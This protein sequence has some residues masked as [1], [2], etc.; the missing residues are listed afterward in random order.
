M[1]YS[2]VYDVRVRYSVDNKA[3]RSGTQGLKNDVRALGQEAK[4]TTGIFGRLGVAVVA[5][6]GARA[7]GKALI[8]FNSTVEDT[9]NQIA[10]MLALS[11]KTDL[12]Q[13][14]GVA[15]RLYSRLEKRAATLP[16]KTAEYVQM[17]GMLTQPLSNAGAT[18]KDMENLTVNA[19][20]GAKALGVSWDVAARDMDQA[21]R[22]QFHSVDQFTG[23]ILGSIGYTG[24]EGRKRFNEMGAD[25]RMEVLKAALMQ[26]QLTQL[27]SAQG[28]SFS[29]VLSTLQDTIEKTLGK[30]GQPIFKALG[31]EIR[32]WNKWLEANGDR[33]DDIAKTIG[34]HLV[35]G[36]RFVKDTLGFFVSHADTLIM[37][38]KVWAAVKIGSML[39]GGAGGLLG[40]MV[41][42]AEG[43]A[44][45]GGL[46]GLGAFFR[47][48]SDR[49]NPETG[50]Y[51]HTKA[52]RGRQAVGGMKGVVD[53][54][55]LL[56]S[57]GAAGYAIGNMLGLDKVGSQLGEGLAY[58]T[59]RADGTTRAFEK[60][61]R[62]SAR[63]EQAMRAAAKA[64]PDAPSALR[65][66]A[67]QSMDYA[68]QANLVRDAFAAY[69]K[70]QRTGSTQDA[71]D[72]MMKRQIAE[73]AGLSISDIM[74]TGGPQQFIDSMNAKS[75]QLSARG[76]LA[77]MG[78]QAA[79]ALGMQKL[80]EYQ[81]KTL[82]TEMAQEEISRYMV[83][84][85]ASGKLINP[86]TVMEILRRNTQDPE[87]KHKNV[88][89]KPKVNVT[90]QRI[91]VQSDDPDRMAFGLIESFRDAAKNPS[92][93]LSSLREG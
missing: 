14:V 78:T 12:S 51:E 71:A 93:A 81:R 84:Q 61:E 39:G 90:I 63:L 92:S 60:L 89:D 4:R 25:K 15:D 42:G 83:Q 57:S 69:Q 53:N 43:M 73:Q 82:E 91:E 2:T 18:L 65:N 86:E 9:K 13:Q 20:V 24:E 23:K 62:E 3:G 64:G 21:L 88:S 56:A 6:F 76:A 22:G 34:Q 1:S 17:L 8:G 31:A 41:G 33:V 75:G 10:G 52:G 80:T 70:A 16:G 67:G 11:K 58:V 54:L 26:K 87:G 37:V 45:S 7:A 47:G 35:T 77:G 36:F 48:A 29:G 79:I 49:F 19:V 32:D 68:Q 85:L 38:G 28:G 46:R 5:S 59:G 66:L 40:K 50:E 44:G 27:A 74:K 30:V 72:F 55:G